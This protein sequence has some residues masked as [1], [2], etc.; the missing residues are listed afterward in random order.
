MGYLFCEVCQFQGVSGRLLDNYLT[1]ELDPS[2]L[3]LCFQ[4]KSRRI[5]YNIEVKTQMEKVHPIA[6]LD[7]LKL[8]D[9]T[10]KVVRLQQTKMSGWKF[11]TIGLSSPALTQANT[12]TG[13]IGTYA[14]RQER[15]LT[16][17]L[18][19]IEG[20]YSIGG[21]GV[22]PWM[23]IFTYHN[24]IELNSQ[25][26]TRLVVDLPSTGLDRKLFELLGNLIRPGGHTMIWYEED[27]KTYLALRKGVPPVVTELGSLLFWAGCRLVK[28][29]SLPEGGLEG[30]KKLWGEKPTNEHHKQILQKEMAEQIHNFLDRDWMLSE[31]N[32]ESALKA[33]ALKILAE[34]KAEQTSL[35]FLQDRIQR[36]GRGE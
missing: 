10:L 23:E 31:P 13:R 1:A 6:N 36:L 26:K 14:M 15:Y 16:S 19:V 21:K 22:T 18:P 5:F 24:R 9:Y 20:L 8:G 4:I 17:K 34:L 12:H 29:F 11:F 3:G 32:L 35:G 33:G 30:S 27:E 2:L 25:T 7:G 28:D